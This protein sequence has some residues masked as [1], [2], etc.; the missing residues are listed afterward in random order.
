M[1]NSLG[2]TLKN[3]TKCYFVD[4]QRR[5]TSNGWKQLSKYLVRYPLDE[6]IVCDACSCHCMYHLFMLRLQM[7]SR[8]DI[9]ARFPAVKTFCF[10]LKRT[11]PSLSYV[12]CSTVPV[13]AF[14]VNHRCSFKYRTRESEILLNKFRFTCL[15]VKK[16]EKKKS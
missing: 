2:I 8:F 15:R 12:P 6:I 16:I 5:M 1:T 3:V 7:I 10:S 11:C 13:I 9:S 14:I 4:K